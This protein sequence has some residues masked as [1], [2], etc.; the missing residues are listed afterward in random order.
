MY[1]PKE[2]VRRMLQVPATVHLVSPVSHSAVHLID[3]SRAGVA[4]ASAQPLENGSSFMIYLGLPGSE[5][6]CVAEGTVVYCIA[7]STGSL[8]RIGARITLMSEETLERVRDFITLPKFK[9]DTFE[10][11]RQITVCAE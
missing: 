8:Y 6:P 10:I 9:F 3:I 5:K 11:S 4:F 1:L 2:H 7:P